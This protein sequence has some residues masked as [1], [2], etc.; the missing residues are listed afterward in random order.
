MTA[1]VGLASVAKIGAAG[2][3]TFLGGLPKPVWYIIGGVAILGSGTLLHSC[4]VGKHDR[5][6]VASTIAKEDNRL[7]TD[8]L[9]LKAQADKLNAEAAQ[10][11][12]IKNA[13]AN[14][15][16]ITLTRDILLRGPGKA[17]CASGPGIAPISSG[18][19]A[20][21]GS[22]PGSVAPVPNSGGSDFLALP[23]ADTVAVL[24][25]CSLDRNELISVRNQRQQLE[26]DWPK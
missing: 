10:L 26:K 6:L 24:K 15:R 17:S 8:A 4:E 3:G 11:E 21:V 22:R 19:N 20:P 7:T 16:T 14:T 12:R 9:K 25:Q 13:E 18:P 23:F 1:L 2:F 5:A